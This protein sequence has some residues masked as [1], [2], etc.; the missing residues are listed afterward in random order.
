MRVGVLLSGDTVLRAAHSLVAHP[1]VDQVVI[2]GPATSNSFEVVA[3]VAGCDVL[4]GTG[5]DALKQARR[6]GVRL[7]WDGPTSEEGVSVYGASPQGLAL[8]VAARE[9]DPQL[10]ALA[11]PEIAEGKHQKVRFPDPV[12]NISVADTVYSGLRVATGKSPNQ[13]ATVLTKGVSRR[14]AFV[15][16]GAFMSGV[17]LAAGIAA[18]DPDSVNAVWDSALAYLKTATEMGLVMAE[19]Q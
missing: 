18:F 16:D 14:V 4:V 8:S 17:A 11:H 1:S 13:F 3:G 7:I 6:H 19:G 12:G 15:D 9:S 5:P 10:V 2:V